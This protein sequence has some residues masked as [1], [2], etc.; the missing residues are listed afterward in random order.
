[1]K[2]EDV[3]T[4]MKVVKTRPYT[5]DQYCA[6]GGDESDV[7]IGAVGVVADKG[8]TP[9]CVVVNFPN[10]KYGWSVDVHEIELE[11]PANSTPPGV[12]IREVI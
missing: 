4:G 3:K 12:N 2:I 9:G 8:S 7:P 5:K 1:M 11:V 10:G 6:Y